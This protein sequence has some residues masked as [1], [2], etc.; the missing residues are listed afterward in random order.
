MKDRQVTINRL[1]DFYKRNHRLPTY[2]EM[3]KLLHYRSK[4]SGHYLIKNLI[5]EG[6][7]SK[8]ENGQLVPKTLLDIP[9]L[10]KIKA[11]YPVPA[12]VSSDYVFNFHHLFSDLSNDSFALTVSGDSMQDAGIV[13][14]DTVIVDKS[15]EATNGDVIAAIVDNERTVKYFFKD[16]DVITLKPANDKYPDIHPLYNFLIGGV[17]K[18]VVRSY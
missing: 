3:M 8:D 4:G 14:G 1:K 13:D 17:V 10:G 6:L 2:G 18:H 16:G 9:I 15:I 12:E 5:E 11:G 7:I